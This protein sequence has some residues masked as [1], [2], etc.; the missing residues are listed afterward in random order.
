MQE[1]A[2]AKCWPPIERERERE[3]ERWI[4]VD[5]VGS[6]ISI[7]DNLFPVD[8]EKYILYET[9][10][11][12]WIIYS[13]DYLLVK[14]RSRCRYRGA[15]VEKINRIEFEWR[16]VKRGYWQ[17]LSCAWS[18]LRLARCLDCHLDTNFQALQS[19]LNFILLGALWTHN[20][21]L[22]TF[23]WQQNG[24]ASFAFRWT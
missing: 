13:L 1:D 12:V 5:V 2:I 24:V 18:I 11:W 8:V 21:L 3:R 9:G 15:V 20:Y 14:L 23:E 4:E 7:D 16:S 10:W 17:Y 6:S 19:Q 22:L